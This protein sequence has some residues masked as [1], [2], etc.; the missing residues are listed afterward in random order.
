MGS[1]KVRKIAWGRGGSRP[2][3]TIRNNVHFAIK[4]HPKKRVQNRVSIPREIL[5]K[6]PVYAIIESDQTIKIE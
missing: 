3:D 2:L 4:K 5:K 1:K 6:A